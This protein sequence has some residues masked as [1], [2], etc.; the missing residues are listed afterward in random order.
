MRWWRKRPPEDFAEEIRAHLDLE[1]DELEWRGLGP[2]AARDAA[3]RAFGNVT[4]ARERYHER[5]RFAGW[6]YLLKDIGYAGR[7]L[8]KSKWFTASATAIL[9]LAIG[10]NLTVFA[11]VDGVMLRSIPVSR[12][13]EL[14]RV[15]PSAP[16]GR[17]N[18]LPSTVLEPL[19]REAVFSGV[20]GF[21]TP[22]ISANLNGAIAHTNVL[23]M[24]GDCWK[25]LGVE[26]QL[27]RPFSPEDDRPDAM[28][29]VVLSASLWRSAFG[30]SPDV[31]GRQIQAGAEMYTVIGVAAERFTGVAPGYRPGLII[32][33]L[34]MPTDEPGRRYAYHW[35]TVFARRAAGVSEAA[36]AAR[37]GAIATALLEQS[38]PR[39]FDAAQ[40]RQ[41]LA[42]R[43]TVAPARTG[44]DLM[45]RRRFGGPLMALWGVCAV[46]LLIACLNLAS[47]LVARAIA[48]QK[49]LTIRLAIGATR[50]RVIR[51]LAFESFLLAAAGGLAGAALASW[52]GEAIV[53]QAAT[54]FAHL[55]LET[56][57][58]A[59]CAAALA[60]V[61]FVV[62][63]IL[64][65]VPV[66]QA[67]RVAES[68]GLRAAGRGVV[69]G[70]ARTQKALIA[71]QVAFTLALVAVGGVFASSFQNL[72]GLRLGMRVE[73]TAQAMLS[74]VPGG[75]RLQ[76]PGAYYASLLETVRSLPGVRS[77]SLTD[78]AL[79]WYR[80]APE[81]VR[82]A[83]GSGQTRAQTIR[84]SHGYF[85]SLGAQLVAGEDFRPESRAPEAIVSE[86]VAA[87]LGGGILG[88]SI[89]LGEKQYRVIGVAPSM[90]I[91]M[92]D[93]RE[94]RGLVYLNFWLERSQQRYPV[95]LAQGANGRPPDRQTI[96]RALEARGV[97]YVQ[98][99]LPIEEARDQSIVED[100]L[101]A[102]LS[103]VFSALA[104]ALAAIG[105]F[106]I[107][108]SYVSRRTGEFGV[109]IAL[110]ANAADLRRLVL[111]QI[112][113]VLGLGIAT[114]LG[115]AAAAGRVLGAIAYGVAPGDPKLLGCAVSLVLAAAA[116]AA[117][118]PARRAASIQPI[119]AL[120]R[121]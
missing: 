38:V 73:D 6:D 29:V 47:L 74:P 109:R 30:G 42:Y 5:R 92:A 115:L 68:G 75:Y 14:V 36:A 98:D 60:A 57:L 22:R 27:G 105:L 3:R 37:V 11:L 100:R 65:A 59:R 101:L 7:M 44:A 56:S 72:A 28:N 96:A 82:T 89:V 2:E 21:A 10:A 4:A 83:D 87:E 67:S 120:R 61:V 45:L 91:S 78:F 102:Y 80:L 34:R 41:Y 94:S 13:D 119:E 15:D 50:W 93:V 24:S 25:T 90:T 8:R 39:R 117:W 43:L 52:A 54:V 86:T 70:G 64:T 1:Q 81:P 17:V 31:L 19:R 103:V 55:S 62:A 113:L 84:V 112:G 33:L 114:G 51:P 116:G 63:A 69:G 46:V 53:T 76:D 88:R 40:R 107:L 16:Q 104:L 121:D 108:S 32:P 79:F 12:P 71:I 9:A 18:G 35:V 48:R 26:T 106:A 20:C 95:L 99:Y 23:A 111:R 118:I 77:A 110:G 49:E 85:R 97:E 66:W 58:S